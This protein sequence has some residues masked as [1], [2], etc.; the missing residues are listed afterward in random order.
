M[1]GSNPY[2]LARLSL[3]LF[4][5]DSRSFAEILLRSKPSIALWLRASLLTVNRLFLLCTENQRHL[6]ASFDTVLKARRKSIRYASPEGIQVAVSMIRVA[7]IHLPSPLLST[8]SLSLQ[9][10]SC[11]TDMYR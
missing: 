5:T 9:S 1:D 8:S 3:D 7:G 11:V 4:C 6:Y 2:S 10:L